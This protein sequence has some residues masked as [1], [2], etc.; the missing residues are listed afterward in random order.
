ME[1]NRFN[2]QKIK[3]KYLK[4]LSSQE[5]MSEPFRDKLGQL[6]T[7]ADREGD[8]RLAKEVAKYWGSLAV[9]T[10]IVFGLSALAGAEVGDE[11][12]EPDFGKL[13]FGNMR[14]DIFAGV[15][16]PMRLLAKA[17]DSA[18]KTSTGQEVKLDLWKET[19]NTLIK[20]KVTP[21]VSGIIELLQGKDFVS[22]QDKSAM[23]VLLQRL[24]PIT[25]SNLYE[26]VYERDAEGYQIFTEFAAEFFG[27]SVYTQT[28][29]GGG[30]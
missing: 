1:N 16:Q 3:N 21:W 18:Y 10:A 15:G 26:N 29:R 9:T 8:V 23:K 6:K 27:L 4:F 28:R 2:Y 11:P 17:L 22:R 20:Y 13:I 12:D 19:Q 24:A 14:L 5:V 25:F 30:L 7:T